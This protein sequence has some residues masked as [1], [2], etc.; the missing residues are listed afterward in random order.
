MQRNGRQKPSESEHLH[1]AGLHLLDI[2]GSV[3]ILIVFGVWI[4]FLKSRVKMAELMR[5]QRNIPCV[6]PKG[7]E[8]KGGGV[9][10]D[11]LLKAAGGFVFPGL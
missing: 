2:H 7:T 4:D 9:A 3:P 6:A 10:V 1:S 5:K 8:Q 11:I